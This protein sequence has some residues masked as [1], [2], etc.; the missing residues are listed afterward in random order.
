MNEFHRI[1]RIAQALLAAGITIASGL[2]FQ[3]GHLS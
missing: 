1:A 3:F 2:I